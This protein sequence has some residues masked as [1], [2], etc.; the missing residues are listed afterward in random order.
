[1]EDLNP[2]VLCYYSD[3]E[4]TEF[5]YRRRVPDSLSGAT[6]DSVINIIYSCHAR[7]LGQIISFNA[8]NATSLSG[9]DAA[10]IEEFNQEV[11]AHYHTL[12][13]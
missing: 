1:M 7:T 11:V 10:T 4:R 2:Y 6:D 13:A 3:H 5:P 12:H 9:L 8:F